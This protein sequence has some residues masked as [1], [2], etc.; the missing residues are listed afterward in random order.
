MRIEA[1]AGRREGVGQR[2]RKRHACG[3][4]SAQEAGFQDTRGAHVEH[5]PHGCDSGRVEAQWLV[6]HRRTLPRRETRARDAVRGAG[7]PG[8]GRRVAGDR[9]ASSV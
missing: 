4:G 3:E 8:L 2:R 5:A 7:R 9:A 1:R 6:E